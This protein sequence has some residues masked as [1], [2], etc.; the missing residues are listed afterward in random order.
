M[1]RSIQLDVWQR[2]KGVMERNCPAVLSFDGRSVLDG[3][4]MLFIDQGF[5]VTHVFLCLSYILRKRTA[6]VCFVFSPCFLKKKNY[7]F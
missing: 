4:G 3:V 2:N 5:V 7:L 6:I 1:R